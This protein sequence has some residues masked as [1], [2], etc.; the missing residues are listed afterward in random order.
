MNTIE[1]AITASHAAT[2]FANY[3]AEAFADEDA[4]A[5]HRQCTEAISALKQEIRQR[6]GLRAD[7][8][9]Q[10]DLLCTTTFVI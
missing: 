9:P 7:R 3:A 10:E 6:S 4:L 2:G 8:E 5:L 1:Q